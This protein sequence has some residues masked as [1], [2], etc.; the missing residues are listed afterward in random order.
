MVLSDVGYSAT[1]R[2]LIGQ[3]QEYEELMLQL[4]QMYQTETVTAPCDGVVS[5]VDVQQGAAV[6]AGAVLCT[7]A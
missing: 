5:S 3:R 2:Q 1:Y 6:D 4:F 7:L